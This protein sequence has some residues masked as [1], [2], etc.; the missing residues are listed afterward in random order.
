VWRLDRIEASGF[1][2]LTLFG[3]P[4]FDLRVDSENWCLEGQNGSGKTSLANAI[5][6]ALTGK[7]IREQDGPVELQCARMPVS[8]DE[9][10][11]IGEWPFLASYPSSAA[12]LVKSVEV[13]VRLTFKNSKDESATAYRRLVCP[14]QNV[15]P[16]NCDATEAKIDP[17]LL[18]APE[19]LE[20]GLLMPARIARIGFGDKS[21]SLYEAVKMLTGLDQLADIAEGCSQFTHGGRRFL[22]YGK[23]NGIDGFHTRFDE[24]MADAQGKAKEISFALPENRAIGDKNVVLDLKACAASASAEAG[25]YLATLKSE[26]APDIDTAL[27]EGR[28]KVRNAV[29]AARAIANQGAKGIVVFEAWKALKEAAQHKPFAG[30]PSRLEDVHSKLDRALGWHRRQ[31]ADTRFRLKAMAAQSFIPPHEHTDNS[32]CPL[33]ASVLS[34]DEQRA[35]AAELAEL[36]SDAEEAER[37]ID[38]V[39]RGLQAEL[40]EALPAGLQLNWELLSAMDPRESYASAIVQ[41]FCGEPPFS[42]ILI[43][44][45]ARLKAVVLRQQAMLPSFSFREFYCDD[46]E[47]SS[48]FALRRIMHEIERV[49]ALVSWWSANR[50][51]FVDSWNDIIGQKQD[52]DTYPPESIEGELQTLELALAKADPLDEV[53]RLLFAAVKDAESWTDVRKEQALR[54]AIAKGLEPLKDLRAVVGAETA[55]SITNLSARMRDILERIHLRERLVYGQA[56]L[57]KKMVTVAGGFEPGMQIDAALVANTS[58]L[59]AILW[60]FVLALR[61]EAIKS[62]G[63]NPFPLMVLDDPQTTFDPRNKRKWAQ[64][65]ARLANMDRNQKQGIQLLLTTN[66]RLF[67]QC[68]VDHE[69]LVGQQGLIAGVNKACGVATI[70]NGGCLERK[71]TEALQDNNDALGR[72]YIAAVRIY[73]EDLIKFML[74]GEGSNIPG[75]T[76]DKLKKELKQRHDS[77][78]AP[79]DRKVF[80]DLN[81]TLSDGGKAMKLI[82]E[83]HHKG[84]ESIGL[85]QAKDVREFWLARLVGKIHDAFDAFDKFESFYGEPRTFSWAKKVIEFPAGFRESVAAVTFQRTGIAAAAKSD[86][87]AGDGI[88]TVEEWN[89]STPIVLPNHELY[90]LAAGT[91]DPVAGIGD[92][93]IVSNYAKPNP[94]NLVVAAFGESLLARRYNRI[95]A[96]P[97]IIVLTGQS[98]DP[99]ALPEPIIVSPEGTKIKKIVGTVFAARELPTPVLDV[100][101]EFVPLADATVVASILDGTRLFQVQGRSAEPIA[102]DGQF[103]ITRGATKSLEAVKALDGR[104]IV[105]VDED[106]TRFFKRLRCSGSVAVLESLNPDGTTAAELL[107][108]DGSLGLP[109]LTQALE[110]I[111]VLFEL[112]PS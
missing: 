6:W 1:G 29:G 96:H 79:F 19:F 23:E 57:G 37:K 2:G 50:Q 52:D 106:G 22:R 112:P 49:V 46:G 89:A 100:T 21:Q 27:S 81:N 41:R 61:E 95:E 92:V 43:G 97:E 48:V 33:C 34:S 75:M 78:V 71:W 25:A 14:C 9:G 67:Y 53:S 13:W 12:D 66:E 56:C 110:V 109:K 101:R 82:N 24:H 104:P 15:H 51:L 72:D 68:L 86:G 108:F 64:E 84:D 111:G 62:L 83:S 88:V 26:I 20:T 45:A 99:L 28:L 38:D 105:A 103:L 35:L 55:R 98:V 107:S 70:V 91:L 17:R 44:L 10:G 69:K 31:L 63:A 42:D 36:R 32:L 90:Q 85:A 93:L 87:L 54:E 76:L 74:R 59:R 3:G 80:T 39:C 58:W 94:R 40:R 60:A 8:N 18:V 65:L 7:R 77:H 5:L 47:L 30:L 4:Q 16:S 11:K 102:L 73:C